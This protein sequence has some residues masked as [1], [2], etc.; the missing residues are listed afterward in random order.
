MNALAACYAGLSWPLL[1]AVA[2]VALLAVCFVLTIIGVL[3]YLVLVA[4]V[5]EAEHDHAIRAGEVDYAMDHAP[6]G[7]PL[8]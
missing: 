6:R 3:L 1:G 7:G 2:G 5:I 4:P 8:W